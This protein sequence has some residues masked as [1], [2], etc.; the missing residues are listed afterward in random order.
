ME[1]EIIAVNSSEIL[2]KTEALLLDDLRN[3][4]NDLLKLIRNPEYQFNT[5]LSFRMLNYYENES[6]LR[7]KRNSK[8][9]KRR[10]SFFDL[11]ALKFLISN[12]QK[13][14]KLERLDFKELIDGVMPELSDIN[15]VPSKFEMHL[16]VALVCLGIKDINLTTKY[17]EVAPQIKPYNLSEA[18]RDSI[19][20][21]DLTLYRNQ[22]FITNVIY[23]VDR[24][25]L[26][27]G[28]KVLSNENLQEIGKAP[29][30]TQVHRNRALQAVP[31]FLKSPLINEF[32]NH[33]Y[34]YRNDNGMVYGMEIKFLGNEDFLAPE[35]RT[36]FSLSINEIIKKTK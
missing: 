12:R 21:L 1:K 36:Q 30:N 24:L 25:R 20:N 8:Q 19:S 3:N 7:A 2:K 35:D 23:E 15:I 9:G 6:M 10:I 27:L 32:K 11:Q 26:S 5:G 33:S 17:T 16:L 14:S 31:I 28:L 13:T 22:E 18:I 34:I 29:F 4:Y